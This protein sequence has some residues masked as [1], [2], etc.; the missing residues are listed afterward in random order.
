MNIKF[1]EFLRSA[2]AAPS[3]TVQ[4]AEAAR[5]ALIRRLS[6]VLR[7]Q[8]VRY[9]QPI[10]MI[11]GV[12]DHRLSTPHPS[13]PT[14]QQDASNINKFAKA[15]M[16]QCMDISNWLAPMGDSLVSATQGVQECMSLMGGY[17]NFKGFH[18]INNVQRTDVQLRHDA[19]RS[20]LAAALL[21]L[22]DELTQPSDVVMDSYL[23]TDHFA[24]L[25]QIKSSDR[26]H[27]EPYDDGY[28]KLLWNDLRAIAAVQDVA[29][30]LLEDGVSMSFAMEPSRPL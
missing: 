3:A 4:E 19:L 10:N 8:L 29:L 6:P 12:M 21:V 26:A 15:A 13:L 16:A 9:L 5:Y 7:H 28:R 20:T 17:L 22:T 23:D 24:L 2:T 11:Y 27:C 18:L 14:L 25:I 1:S 30:R